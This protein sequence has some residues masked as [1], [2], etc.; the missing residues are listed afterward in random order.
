MLLGA[1]L[2]MVDILGGILLIVSAFVPFGE[3]GFILTMGAV[4]LTKGVL[5]LVYSKF[6]K[7]HIDWGSLLDLVTGV[8]LVLSF[9]SIYNF[10]FPVIGIFMIAK[11]VIKF[12]TSLV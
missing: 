9:Y 12:A 5:L 7:E 8:L 2:S 6:S 10:I 4:F 11:G 1:I 3:S